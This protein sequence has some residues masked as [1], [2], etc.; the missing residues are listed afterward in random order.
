MQFIRVFNPRENTIVQLVV[1]P[2]DVIQAQYF[3]RTF[4]GATGIRYRVN[5]LNEFRRSVIRKLV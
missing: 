4:P 2:A 3:E 5:D 1:Q